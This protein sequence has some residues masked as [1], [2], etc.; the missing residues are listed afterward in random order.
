VNERGFTLPELLVVAVVLIA[1]L[2]VSVFF[3]RPKSYDNENNDAQRRLGLA[4]MA[5]A[6]AE[7]KAEHG[8]WPPGMPGKDTAIATEGGGVDLCKV[9]VPSHLQDMPLDPQ[10]GYAFT[11]DASSPEFT[12]DPCNDTGVKYVTGYAVKLADNT[13]TLS[14]ITSKAQTLAISVR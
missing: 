6:L 8:I 5:Q 9:L 11:G 12:T 3:L 10:L 1:L 13:V 14:A 7:Y 2:A 4:V